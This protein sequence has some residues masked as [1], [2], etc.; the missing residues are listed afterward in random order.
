MTTR[1]EGERNDGLEL[2]VIDNR[3][4]HKG[5]HERITRAAYA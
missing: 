2:S 1:L 5:E 4:D 3:C